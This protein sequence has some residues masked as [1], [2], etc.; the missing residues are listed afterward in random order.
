[1]G[2]EHDRVVTGRLPAAERADKPRDLR[3]YRRGEELAD[4][5]IHILGVAAGIGG[6]LALLMIVGQQGSRRLLPGVALYAFG[7]LAM[8]SCSA[9]YNMTRA[10]ARKQLYRRLDHAAIF[11]MIAGSYTPFLLDRIGGGWVLGVL[12]FVWLA[13]I[14]GAAVAVAAPGRFERLQ[15]AAYLVLGWCILLL[16]GRLIAAVG[17]PAALLLTVGGLFYSFGVVFHLWRRLAYHN[18]M[19]HGFVLIGAGCHYA[20]VLVGVVLV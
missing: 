5:C 14:A 1:M 9:L 2:D 11:I 6:V 13:A 8:F 18:A 19:W 15:L 4:R 17:L 3:V 10:P 20:A 12:A 16:G 7:L